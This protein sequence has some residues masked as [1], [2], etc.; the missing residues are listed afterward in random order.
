MLLWESPRI[1]K[2]QIAQ[3]NAIL[4]LRCASLKEKRK[5]KSKDESPKYLAL[6]A[7]PFSYL[8]LLLTTLLVILKRFLLQLKT[9]T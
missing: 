9:R 3:M 1:D 6:Y 8:K 7:V 5:Y 4:G 2:T